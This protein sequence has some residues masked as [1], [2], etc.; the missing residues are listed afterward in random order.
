[1]FPYFDDRFFEWVYLLA[2]AALIQIAQIGVY[3]DD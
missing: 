1:M 2:G 3:L